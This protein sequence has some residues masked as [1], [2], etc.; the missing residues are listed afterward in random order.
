[1]TLILDSDSKKDLRMIKEIALKFG[2]KITETKD[3]L[4]SKTPNSVTKKAMRDAETGKV[5]RSKNMD[6]LMQYLN[7]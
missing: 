3:N 2:M 7:S 6:D 1:M 5:Y 4:K